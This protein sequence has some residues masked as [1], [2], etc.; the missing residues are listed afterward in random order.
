M[1]GV[2][3]IDPGQFARER[4]TAR[5]SF[6]ADALVRLAE[7][8]FD[9]AGTDG[10]HGGMIEYRVTGFVTPKDEAGLRIDVSGEIELRCQRCMERLK[11]PLKLQREIVLV[12]GVD[13][14]AQSADEPESVDT[15]PAV[16]RI[17]LHELVEEEILL[18][19]PLA[20]RHAGGECG[21]HEAG[22]APLQGG[23]SPFATL[24]RLKH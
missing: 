3:I 13:E 16:G 6:G 23:A 20:P 21:L 11:L 4:A 18:A 8:L 19:L 12:A 5:G 15:I 7:V 17:D 1:M 14:F 22:Q 24:A 9:A 10:Q 2:R